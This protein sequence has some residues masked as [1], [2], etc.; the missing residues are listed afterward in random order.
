MTKNTVET[1]VAVIGAGPVGLFAVFECGMLGLKCHVIDALGAPGG[2]CSALYPEKP[3][4][5]IPGHPA[6]DAAVLVEKLEQ[7]AEPFSP[8]YRLNERIVG[9]KQ[10][11]DSFTLTTSSGDTVTAKAVIIAAGAGG[12]DH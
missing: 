7:Q 2:Q 9:L 1:D 10:D 12:D 4:Y 8:T 3:I 6:I 11:G 5:D